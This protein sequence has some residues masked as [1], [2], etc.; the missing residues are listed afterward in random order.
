[1]TD[2]ALRHWFVRCGSIPARLTSLLIY[3]V[4]ER[5]CVV[6][7]SEPLALTI[8]WSLKQ[9]IRRWVEIVQVVLERFYW[10]LFRSGDG[11]C[12]SVRFI[13]CICEA[14]LVIFCSRQG[15]RLTSVQ[16]LSVEKALPVSTV[17][18]FHVPVFLK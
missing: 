11:K 13:F 17:A 9:N 8:F 6:C 5:S 4:I 2:V 3:H 15:A 12:L 16:E 10:T 18:G 1:M 7:V 14:V